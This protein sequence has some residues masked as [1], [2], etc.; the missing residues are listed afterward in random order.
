MGKVKT[1]LSNIGKSSQSLNF[2]FIKLLFF[3]LR[4]KKRSVPVILNDRQKG[5]NSYARMF[6]ALKEKKAKG[7]KENEA[8][9]VV[10]NGDVNHGKGAKEQFNSQ[11]HIDETSFGG[12]QSV[13]WPVEQDVHFSNNLAPGMSTD[14]NFLL[15]WC[16]LLFCY[17]P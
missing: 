7:A 5:A 1:S 12:H 9:K 8:K 10:Q 4:R 13:G 17:F 14:M 16:Y 15:Y 2:A 3:S 11:V 6:A